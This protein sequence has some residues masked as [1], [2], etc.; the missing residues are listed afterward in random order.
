MYSNRSRLGRAGRG[1]T[2]QGLFVQTLLGLLP[3]EFGAGPLW[4]TGP[5]PPVIQGG[6]EDSFMS[7][8]HAERQRGDESRIL[9][10]MACFGEEEFWFL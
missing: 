5:G 4:N 6:S 2:Q 7:A 8:S 10:R 1:H 9:G 3:S